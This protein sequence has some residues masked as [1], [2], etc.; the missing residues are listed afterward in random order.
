MKLLSLPVAAL[1]A[2]GAAAGLF[3]CVTQVVGG[4]LPSNYTGMEIVAARH[5]CAAMQPATL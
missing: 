5:W 2:I 1:L 4:G 3:A